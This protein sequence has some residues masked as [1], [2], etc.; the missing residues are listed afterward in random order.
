[1]NSLIAADADPAE[2]T[3]HWTIDPINEISA[4]TAVADEWQALAAVVS[5]PCVTPG[6]MLGFGSHVHREPPLWVATV[7]DTKQRLIGLAPFYVENRSRSAGGR[8]RLLTDG[9]GA[10]IEWQR[11]RAGDMWR[12]PLRTRCGMR[13]GS[14][15]S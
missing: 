14:Q 13:V 1:M 7:R 5:L 15:A 2:A 8:Y 11:Q 9:I 10:H 4:L 12:G 3:K 6:W